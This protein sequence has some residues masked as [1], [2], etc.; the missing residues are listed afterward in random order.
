MDIKV[1]V[2]D[3]NAGH[4]RATLFVNGANA[5]QVCLRN[6]E[7][8]T[9]FCEVLQDGTYRRDD[10]FVLECVG[11]FM[12]E[13]KVASRVLADFEKA[14]AILPGYSEPEYDIPF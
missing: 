4:V 3:R 14:A 11:G 8:F 6:G 12:A 10:E 13:E 5:G 2:D 9:R 1:R 7:E